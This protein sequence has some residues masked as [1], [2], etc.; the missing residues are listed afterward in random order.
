MKKNVSQ[1]PN[2]ALQDLEILVGDWKMELANASFLPSSSETM[3]GHASFEW[4]EQ[5]AF[6]VMYMGSQPMGTPDAIWLINRDASTPNYVVLYYDNR[7]VSRVY[8][9]SFL[10]GTWKMWRNS[11]DF[12]Q[13]FEGK[14][15]DDGN[16][17]TA[18][19][20]KSSNGS[21]W[22]NDFNITYRKVI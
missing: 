15:S 21:I 2:P 17:I 4:L 6:L 9:M 13:R 7:K 20:E 16:T 19:W 1:N 8:E 5:G 14:V 3:T 22:E 11:P 18:H 12:S 10:D